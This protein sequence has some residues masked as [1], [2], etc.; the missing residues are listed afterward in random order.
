MQRLVAVVAGSW[1]DGPA[2]EVPSLS[3]QRAT[4]IS[5]I[6]MNLMEVPFITHAEVT[7]MVD[8][9]RTFSNGVRDAFQVGPQLCE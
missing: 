7:D 1:S 8:L 2:A 5:Y 6:K 9:G 4:G 3:H